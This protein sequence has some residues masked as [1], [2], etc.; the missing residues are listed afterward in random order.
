MKDKYNIYLHGEY[1]MTINP[2]LV[3]SKKISDE[4]LELI[5]ELHTERLLIQEKMEQFSSE[6]KKN[7]R[8]F[9]SDWTLVQKKLQRAWNSEENVKFH[10]FW[11]VPH[12]ICPNHSSGNYQEEAVFY[13]DPECPVHGN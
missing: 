9:F 10:P 7:L 13:F 4:Q 12:C 11:Q 2:G 8:E 6:D 3:R 1:K 5:R